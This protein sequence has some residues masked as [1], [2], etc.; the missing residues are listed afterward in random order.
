MPRTRFAITL[1][2][3]LLLAACASPPPRSQAV[4][5]PAPVSQQA[6]TAAAQ[7]PLPHYR[8]D[9]GISFTVR[10]DDGSADIDAGA[11][12]R[13]TLWR[14]A[15]GVTPAQ[16]VYSS[17]S[18]KAEFGLDPDGR[19]AKLNYVSPPLEAHCLRD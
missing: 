15:G 13:E 18:M 6:S 1:I 7:A 17:T 14:D 11:R 9:Q 10:F 16:S 2:A 4:P 8:C 19:G 5:E 12:G 3:T